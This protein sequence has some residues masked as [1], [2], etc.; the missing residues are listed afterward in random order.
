MPTALTLIGGAVAIL[1]PDTVVEESGLARNISMLR[2]ALGDETEEAHYI[3]TIP[4]RGYRFVAELL[5]SPSDTQPS[6]K[7]RAWFRGWWAIVIPAL[8]AL[9]VGI[10]WQ[11]YRPSRFLPSGEGCVN[12]ALIPFESQDSE[13]L[14][15]SLEDLL[16]ADLARLQRIRMLSPSTVRHYRSSP[17]TR[18]PKSF[19]EILAS[20]AFAMLDQVF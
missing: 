6:I 18:W 14:T 15:S 16:V 17:N 20:K 11:F 1:W 9:G 3:E 5:E 13:P 8:G 12:V 19:L 4:R 10:Y 2:R 7:R